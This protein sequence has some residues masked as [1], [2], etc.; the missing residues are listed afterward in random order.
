MFKCSLNENK[1]KGGESQ[2][3]E[4]EKTVLLIP[5]FCLLSG[6]PD[7]FDEMKRREV[8][9]YTIVAPDVKKTRIDDLAKSFEK[10]L[11]D[12]GPTSIKKVLNLE[13]STQS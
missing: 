12:F 3:K 9:K 5:E 10:N 2:P 1:K 11:K 7:D 8:S 13:I 4:E 6:L